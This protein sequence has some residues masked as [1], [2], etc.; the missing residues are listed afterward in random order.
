MIL[1]DALCDGRELSDDEPVA[2][3]F[4]VMGDVMLK[5]LRPFGVVVIGVIAHYDIWAGD[6]VFDEAHRRDIGVWIDGAGSGP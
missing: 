6:D 3:K 1:L 4:I 5:I 2:Q